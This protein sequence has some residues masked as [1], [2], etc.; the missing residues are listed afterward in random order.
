MDNK[1][2]SV[3][4]FYQRLF[5][6][7]IAVTKADVEGIFSE[8][9]GGNKGV[10]EIVAFQMAYEKAESKYE[11]FKSG[12]HSELL[13]RN[14]FLRRNDITSLVMKLVKSN[15]DKKS[16]DIPIERALAEAELM[17]ERFL[18][19]RMAKRPYDGNERRVLQRQ[20]DF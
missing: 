7:G 20:E 6:G 4:N 1:Y 15:V 12:F 17:Y 2:A 8:I 13:K 11:N 16:E 14:V 10:S 18:S 9:E 19:L 5:A 3:D